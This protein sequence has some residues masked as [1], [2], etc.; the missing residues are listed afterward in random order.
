MRDDREMAGEKSRPAGFK[1]EGC[2]TRQ[3][4]LRDCVWTKSRIPA[5]NLTANILNW[6]LVIFPEVFP[7]A[8]SHI[9]PGQ[10]PVDLAREF[11]SL[12]FLEL[13]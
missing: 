5:E 13:F 12:P 3:E 2:G 4:A 6:I 8:L 7:H 9:A 10:F 1:G 11:P